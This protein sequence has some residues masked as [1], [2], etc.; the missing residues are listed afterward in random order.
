MYPSV[1]TDSAGSFTIDTSSPTLPV[2]GTT[3]NPACRVSFSW[4]SIDAIVNSSPNPLFG[5]FPAFSGSE[6]GTATQFVNDGDV[7]RLGLNHPADFCQNNPT[8]A[9]TCLTYGDAS[10]AS[11]ER[12]HA[13]SFPYSSISQY[14]PFRIGG[15]EGAPAVTA[16]APA[17]LATNAQVGS[18]WGIAYHKP[19]GKLV[20]SAYLKRHTAVGLAGLGQIYVIGPSQTVSNLVNLGAAGGA[21]PRTSSPV[22]Y[23]RDPDIVS[24]T[25]GVVVGKR[26][27]GD[28]D[29]S[30]DGTTLYAIG[31]ASRSLFIMSVDAN[32]TTVTAPIVEVALPAVGTDATG[33]ASSGD[34]RPFAL[35]FY[36]GSV[37]VG[38]TCTAE[39]SGNNSQLRLFV[40]RFDASGNNPVQVVNFRPTGSVGWGAWNN[41][42]PSGGSGN[43]NNPQ[44]LLTDIEFDGIGTMLL[45]VR[46]RFGDI[47]GYETLPI[48]T[49]TSRVNGRANGDTIR[50]CL[51]A[52]M[53]LPSS[54][55]VSGIG[56]YN[57]QPTFGANRTDPNG[58]L[59]GLLQIP[60]FADVVTTIK[61]PAQLY[62][63]GVGWMSHADGSYTK[64]YEV[65]VPGPTLGSVFVNGGKSGGMGDLEALCDSAPLQVGNRLWLDLNEDGLQDAGEPPIAG[66]IVRLYD[67][68]GD[69]LAT[70]KTDA[71]GT[72]YFSNRK[73]D[74]NG[75]PII[76]PV[77]LT[78]AVF[79]VD[80]LL[81][82]TRGFQLRVDEAADYGSGP[83][84]GSRLTIPN[85]SGV[86]TNNLLTDLVDSDATVGNPNADLGPGNY[87]MIIFDTG[88]PGENNFGLDIGFVQ[89][90]Q[91]SLGNRVWFDAN[92]NG[93]VDGSEE[94]VNGVVVELLTE[95]APGSGSFTPSGTTLTTANGGYSRFDGLSAGNYQVRVNPSNFAAAGPLRGYFTSGTP[96]ADANGDANNDN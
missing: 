59:G 57:D 2:A 34:V 19:S 56:Y 25:E 54:C 24:T 18:T 79:A 17:P 20:T 16:P 75:S 87:P 92:N 95:T 21:N 52:G 86:N 96:T 35:K 11:N 60:G 26:G 7:V 58:S 32:L 62:S 3:A 77:G 61:D 55:A 15:V 6:S 76:N 53:Y 27:L 46:D 50:T 33:C 8:L 13:Y 89:S 70:A 5:M 91:Y 30:D 43:I 78:S 37:Y 45:G 4:N 84:R 44:P 64:G 67:A 93:L 94:G 63:G 73:F 48:G 71:N 36:R 81:S 90:T 82:N 23:D 72:Y 85:A 9:T 14:K 49:S 42:E 68:G 41:D 1:V 80:G 66:A 10:S 51:L 47:T 39:S 38:L 28:I 69:L 74:E 65:L 29:F 40:Y 83:L 88:G 12:P 22:D 31:L